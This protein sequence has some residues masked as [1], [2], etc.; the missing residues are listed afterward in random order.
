MLFVSVAHGIPFSRH[1]RAGR[2]RHGWRLGVSGVSSSPSTPPG[3]GDL[4][5]GPTMPPGLRSLRPRV[6]GRPRGPG[7]RRAGPRLPP[8]R[9]FS[10]VPTISVHAAAP[11]RRRQSPYGRGIVPVHRCRISGHAR[12]GC[13]LSP[14]TGWT[15]MT[16]APGRCAAGGRAPAAACAA[17]IASACRRTGA[18]LPRQDAASAHRHGRPRACHG[19]IPLRQH[20][21]RSTPAQAVSVRRASGRRRHGL[22]EPDTT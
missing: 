13:G 4:Q 2:S 9:P 16:C 10:A 6:G 12:Q 14:M 18:V 7:V 3:A 20:A 21:S 11:R 22:P 1:S 17:A 15:S 5:L 19:P 8:M